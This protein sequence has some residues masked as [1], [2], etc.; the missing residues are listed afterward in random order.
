MISENNATVRQSGNQSINRAVQILKCFEERETLG[1]V[2]ICR[3]TGFPKSTTLGIIFTLEIN[4]LLEQDKATG[5][6]RLGIELFRLGNRVNMDLRRIA[7]PSLDS[8]ATH[9]GETVNFATPDGT[10]VVYIDKRDSIY[11]MRIAPDLGRRRP[12]FTVATG[13]SILAALPDSEALAILNRTDFVASTDKTL[14]SVEAVLEQL[15]EVRRR[16]YAINRQELDYDRVGI[17]AAVRDFS[18]RPVAA[19]S[20]AGPVS[21]MDEVTCARYAHYVMAC[22]QEISQ[23]I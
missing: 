17:A 8:L 22:A 1:L 14:Q 16:G 3:L 21:R 12:M 23:R 19:V 15:Q 9:T 18:G 7:A 5:R 20:I 10:H 2:D 11:T 6:Y 4:G 13:K